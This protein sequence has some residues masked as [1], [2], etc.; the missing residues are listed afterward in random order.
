MK[1]SFLREQEGSCRHHR[2]AMHATIEPYGVSLYKPVVELLEPLEDSAKWIRGHC[3]CANPTFVSPFLRS[4]AGPLDRRSEHPTRCTYFWGF[5]TVPSMPPG[6]KETEARIANNDGTDLK[7]C[8]YNFGIEITCDSQCIDMQRGTPC[9]MSCSRTFS[10]SIER[11]RDLGE[12][13]CSHLRWWP[14][15]NSKLPCGITT[16]KKKAHL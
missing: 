12:A 1:I 16:K 7:R 8:T 3:T 2:F 15:T 6:P 10:Q 13:E 9:I 11:R 4:M 14:N 5:G